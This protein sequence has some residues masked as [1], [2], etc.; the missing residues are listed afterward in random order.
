MTELWKGVHKLTEEA[1]EVLQVLGKLNAYPK[2]NHPRTDLK[3]KLLEELA[4]LDAAL[5]YFLLN[6]FTSA[7]IHSINERAFQKGRKFE[8]WGLSGIKVADDK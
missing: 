2:C 3:A 6:N 1:G 4:D 7:E 5:N 8:Q